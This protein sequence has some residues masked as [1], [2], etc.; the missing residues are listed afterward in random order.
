MRRLLYHKYIVKPENIPD[1]YIKGV[2]FN[3]F[4]EQKGYNRSDLENS[5]I[6]QSLLEQFRNE[7]GHSFESYI[8]PKKERKKY[9][10]W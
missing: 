8:I 4:A 1:E 6:K 3:N 10:R 5:N 2:L 7:T 9:R